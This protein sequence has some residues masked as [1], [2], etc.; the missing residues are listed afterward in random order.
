MRRERT[1]RGL[2]AT[3]ALAIVAMAS[4]SL[5]GTST[6][7]AV[8]A[9]VVHRVSATPA[10]AVPQ[11]LAG[12]V[13]A[14]R[15]VNFDVVLGWTD[16]A[17]VT[18]LAKAVSDPAS[19]S[20]GKY[21]S[22]AD[23]M[24]RFSPSS[25]AVDAVNAW[26]LSQ[27]LTPGTAPA[28][29]VFVPARGTA[30]QVERAFGTTL[31]LYRTGTRVMRAPSSDAVIPASLAGVVQ[32]VV[33]LAATRMHHS[34]LASPPPAFRAGRPCSRY[35]GQ[36]MATDKPMAYGHT[37]A[38]A[39]CGYTPQQI[40][41]AYGLA[42]AISSGVDGSGQ[43]VAIIDAFA[44]RTIRHDLG[45]YSSLHGLPAPNFKQ[46]NEKS[47]PGNA[48]DKQGWY[49]EETLDLEAVHSTAPGAKLIYEGAKDDFDLSFLSRYA[50]ILD[51]HRASII[52]NSYGD[53]GEQGIP[54]SEIRAEEAF[55]QQA[56]VEGIGFFFSSGDCGDEIDPQGAC[57]GS[58][59][60]TADYSAS[61]PYVT[62]VGAAPTCSRRAGAPG[63]PASPPT[64]R[65]GGPRPPAST[66]TAAAADRATCSASPGTRPA[67]CRIRCPTPM[68]ACAVWCPTSRPWVTP[69]PGSWS[70][71]PRRSCRARFATTST[72]WAAPAC[73]HR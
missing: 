8:A 50:D 17:G 55:F 29:R 25:S 63:S 2:R 32:G 42:P 21:L 34:P 62:A 28:S 20:Y 68:G 38:Y 4:F 49:G 43:T 53:V 56:I 23:F 33:G 51:N 13:A 72:A 36:K 35:W 44:A 6:I 65:T 73:P 64:A 11:N 46:Y 60:R 26:L 57:G 16:P 59:F 47:L 27:G 52:T 12:H 3:S 71:R 45:R 58:G 69:T 15:I 66:Y 31:N 61:D 48:A 54:K 7:G 41:G 67:S 14:N 1:R 40:Q 39:P 18:A 5:V 19:P 70:G 9:P 24:A 10:W 37:L 22:P 30:A